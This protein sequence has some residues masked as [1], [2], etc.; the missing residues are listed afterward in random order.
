LQ[1]WAWWP[2]PVILATC[3]AE[4]GRLRFK[5]MLVNSE[6]LSKKQVGHGGSC[7]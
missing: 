2:M 5:T 6:I 7:L 1:G 4:I 3:E